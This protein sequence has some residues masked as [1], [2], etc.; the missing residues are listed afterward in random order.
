MGLAGD[1]GK[2]ED[3]WLIVPSRTRKETNH[4]RDETKTQKVET[5]KRNCPGKTTDRLT[6]VSKLKWLRVIEARIS[7]DGRKLYGT[8]K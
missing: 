6:A 5:G 1:V 7:A 8:D 3:V 4:A 2:H